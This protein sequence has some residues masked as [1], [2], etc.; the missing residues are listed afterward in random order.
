[1]CIV[2]LISICE[3][4]VVISLISRTSNFWIRLRKTIFVISL[5]CSPWGSL[6]QC[7]KGA[8]MY[9]IGGG[10]Y[11]YLLC[12]RLNRRFGNE[13]GVRRY[14]SHSSGPVR[15]IF[16]DNSTSRLYETKINHEKLV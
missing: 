14:Y 15:M 2:G 13:Q 1:M 3:N 16:V 11:W 12:D 7:R 5:I 4:F 9:P 8:V 6:I 10:G